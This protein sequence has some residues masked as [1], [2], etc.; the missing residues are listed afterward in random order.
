MNINIM[1]HCKKKREKTNVWNK[2]KTHNLIYNFF[3]FLIH[4]LFYLYSKYSYSFTHK[5]MQKQQQ[6][7]FVYYLKNFWI[8][9]KMYKNL[10]KSLNNGRNPLINSVR[11][12]SAP[13]KLSSAEIPT[14]V[15]GR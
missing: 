5:V 4:K 8:R 10:L 15:Q 6:T 1:I 3:F 14:M 9:M 11:S 13:K 12:I 7:Y 2:Y